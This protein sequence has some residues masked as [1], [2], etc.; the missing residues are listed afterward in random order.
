MSLPLPGTLTDGTGVGGEMAEWFKAH[1]WKA[2]VAKT[3]RGFESLSLRHLLISPMKPR[4]GF[5]LIELLVVIAIIAIL[6]AMLLP[7]LNMAKAKA[8]G[9][10]CMNNLKQLDTCWHLYLTD[11]GDRLVWNNP[12]SST[13]DTS[14]LTGNM[15]DPAQATDVSFIRNGFLWKYN[16]SL[17]IYRCASDRSVVGNKLKVRSYSR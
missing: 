16:Q 11:N 4:A 8:Q 14:W 17:P 6:A 12:F 7:A 3:H 15:T 1:A 9:I 2:C 10:S 5:T 13:P